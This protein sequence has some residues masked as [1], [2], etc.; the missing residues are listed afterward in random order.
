MSVTES[1]GI[2]SYVEALEAGRAAMDRVR[3]IHEPVD[4]VNYHGGTPRRVQVCS[5]CG[6]DDGNWQHYP[7]PTIRALD[8]RGA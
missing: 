3:A 4:A 1:M 7:C 2:Q 8:G 5:G 6:T